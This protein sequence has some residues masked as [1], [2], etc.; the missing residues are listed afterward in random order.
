M[1]Y[2]LS[3]VLLFASLV[4]VGQTYS[5]DLEKAAKKGDVAAQRDLGICYFNGAG[6][7]TDNQKAFQWLCQAALQDVQAQYYLGVMFEEGRV[8]QTTDKKGYYANLLRT[9]NNDERK[10]EQTN[11]SLLWYLKAASRNSD[12]ALLKLAYIFRKVGNEGEAIKMFQHAADLGNSEAQ[13]EIDKF[14]QGIKGIT[15]DKAKDLII[16]SDNFQSNDYEGKERIIVLKNVRNIPSQACQFSRAKEIIFEEGDEPLHIGQ[17]AFYNITANEIIINRPVYIE[18]GAFRMCCPKLLVFNKDVDY[19][20]KWAF[21]D[22]EG[23][24]KLVFKKVP[25]KLANGYYDNFIHERND[26]PRENYDEINVPAGTENAFVALGIPR[27]KLYSEGGGTLALSI[28]L[29]KPN[30]I[31][32]VLSPDKLSKVDSLTILGFMY[33]TDLKIL[34]DCK[35][36]RYLDLSKTYI[37]Y[38]PEKMKEQRAEKEYLAALFSFMG[39]AADAKFNNYEMGVL[40]HAYVK[41]FAKLMEQS[42]NVKDADDG[43]IIPTYAMCNMMKLE[44]LILPTRASKI[45]GQTFKNCKALKHVKLPPYLKAIGSGAFYG[46]ESL[47]SI[48]FPASLTTIGRAHTDGVL[49]GEGSFMKTGLKKIDLSKCSFE[50]NYNRFTWYLKLKECPNMQEI[51]FPSGVERI[52]LGA[53]QNKKSLTFYVPSTTTILDVEVNV[54]LTIHFASP[55]P[56]RYDTYKIPENSTVYVPKGSMTAYYSAYGNSNKYIEE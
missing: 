43:C 40:D 47:E 50:G 12:E 18:R 46:C 48:D 41:G 32:S 23:V 6:I 31:L 36:M 5:K 30:S 29:E 33:E 21:G 7:D 8:D 2:L 22:S 52:H 25:K 37:T 3:L 20:G 39:E 15:I 45:G 10:I 28:Q 11:P 19:I 24:K 1:K 4:A 38:S 54:P 27:E 16:M 17:D 35:N 34:E 51:K 53:R 42:Y 9:L 55:T 49:E 44:T 13:K 26:Y 56:P 14:Y